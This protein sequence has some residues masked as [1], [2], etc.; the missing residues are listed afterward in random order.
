MIEADRLI[1]A[2]ELDPQEQHVDRAMRPQMLSDYTGQTETKAQLS[3]FI[4]AAKMRDEA[5]DHMLVY[6]PP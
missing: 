1:Q 6:G 3:I 2:E 4:A 5:L